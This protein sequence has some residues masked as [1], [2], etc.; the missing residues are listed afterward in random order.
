MSTEANICGS[1]SKS[2][3]AERAISGDVFETIAFDILVEFIYSTTTFKAHDHK[4]NETEDQ[5]N[6][7]FHCR[8]QILRGQ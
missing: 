2:P 5:V 8:L 1:K 6:R 4:I 3:M 7:F